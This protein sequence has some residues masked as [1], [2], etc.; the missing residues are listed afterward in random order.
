MKKQDV[1]WQ[2]SI[3]RTLKTQKLKDD[4]KEKTVIC[5]YRQELCKTSDAGR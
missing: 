5:F 1:N 2:G 3:I 4:M